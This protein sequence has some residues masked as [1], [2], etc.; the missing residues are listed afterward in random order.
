M[1]ACESLDSE[2]RVG[3]EQLVCGV[4]HS[5]RRWSLGLGERLM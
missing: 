1:S 4:R 5:G 2:D 3:E